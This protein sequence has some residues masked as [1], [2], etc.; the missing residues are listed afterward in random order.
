MKNQTLLRKSYINL[1]LHGLLKQFLWTWLVLRQQ[2][3][4]DLLENCA[5]TDKKFSL[6]KITLGKFDIIQ[7]ANYYDL[8]L[9]YGTYFWSN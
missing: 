1:P 6:T 4:K 5:I 9:E 8:Y 3:I 7:M 2:K